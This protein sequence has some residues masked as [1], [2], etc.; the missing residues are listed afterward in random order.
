MPPDMAFR[1]IFNFLSSSQFAEDET[2]P[3]CASPTFVF[4]KDKNTASS[5]RPL[6]VHGP[7]VAGGCVAPLSEKTTL[8]QA[9]PPREGGEQ[10]QRDKSA[11]R[12]D[13][14]AVALQFVPLVHRALLSRTAVTIAK[15]KIT[16]VIEK[17]LNTIA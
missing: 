15:R 11:D 14:I 9:M 5:P 8:V 3:T 16:K 2:H 10:Y 4:N 6:P 1:S 17:N 13:G 12:V 7:F